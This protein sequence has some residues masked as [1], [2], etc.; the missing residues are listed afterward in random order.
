MKFLK[1]KSLIYGLSLCLTPI[2][3]HAES[4]ATTLY[5]LGYDVPMDKREKVVSAD[6]KIL[7]QNLRRNAATK[8]IDEMLNME[9][10]EYQRDTYNWVRVSD[11][12]LCDYEGSVKCLK[13]I[14]DNPAPFRQSLA[15]L[16]LAMSDIDSLRKRSG[17]EFVSIFPDRLR[18]A[19]EPISGYQYL[20]KPLTTQSA[21]AYY[22]NPNAGLKTVCD[23]ISFGKKLIQSKNNLIQTMIGT[24]LTKNNLDLLEYTTEP[25]PR[26][27]VEALQPMV[28]KDILICPLINSEALQFK[29]LLLSFDEIPILFSHDASIELI[30][31]DTQLFCNNEWLSK[32]SNDEMT[33]SPMK[34]LKPNKLFNRT[35]S[36]LVNIARVD[37]SHYQNRLLDLNANLRLWQAA[38]D[39]RCN[40]AS[41]NY[42]QT[43]NSQ[44][45]PARQLAIDN[46]QRLT[47]IA[48][49]QDNKADDR[50]QELEKIST[51]CRVVQSLNIKF[52]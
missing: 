11:L 18:S 6:I 2:I 49:H 51:S 35:G 41:D 43:I 28:T 34:D 32:V 33:L 20:L 24:K 52:K 13:D 29:N 3:G 46:K 50:L 36:M 15:K 47:I 26:S 8:S 17:S 25:L 48:Y 45:H 30:N 23:N 16:S 21:L 9:S 40:N 10:L 7:A 38:I 27:C 1:S 42:K 5:L 4:A 19:H 12:T 14:Q 31:K 22:D 37:Y 39:P 44:W